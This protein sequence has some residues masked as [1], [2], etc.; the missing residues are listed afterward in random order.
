MKCSADSCFVVIQAVH[1][2]FIRAFLLK[3]PG[4]EVHGSSEMEPKH[5]S[6]RLKNQNS[7]LK[8]TKTLHRA[9]RNGCWMIILCF[10]YS[11]QLISNYTMDCEGL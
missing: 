6:C 9:E 11:E 10:C 7:V 1:S 3:T 8:D 5:S 4:N 2:G